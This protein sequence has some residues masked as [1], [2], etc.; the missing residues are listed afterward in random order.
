[1]A[2]FASLLMA[3]VVAVLMLS[4]GAPGPEGLF[5]FDKLAHLL[6]FAAIAMPLAWRYPRHWRAIALGVLAY[7]G[8]LE[9]VQ[10]MTGRHAEW[11][12]LLADGIGSVSGAFVAARLRR[13]RRDMA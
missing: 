9:L 8:L 13:S 6:S 12:D 11:G 4:P 3:L 7:G 1:M 5:G 2:I 10:P